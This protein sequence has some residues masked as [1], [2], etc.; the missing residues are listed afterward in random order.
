MTVVNRTTPLPPADVVADL[1]AIA[2]AL[3]AE[4]DSSLRGRRWRAPL[5]SPLSVEGAK[6][7]RRRSNV[8]RTLERAGAEGAAGA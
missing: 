7:S 2:D 6:L 4:M 5:D 1:L 3:E 8:H